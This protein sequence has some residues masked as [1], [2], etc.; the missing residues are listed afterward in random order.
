MEKL[1]KSGWDEKVQPDVNE[2]PNE[3]GARENNRIALFDTLA[4]ELGFNGID[5]ST[6]RA[7]IMSGQWSTKL[8]DEVP[9]HCE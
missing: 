4:A 6:E 3:A 2:T 8:P 5:A 9:R 7:N 1:K